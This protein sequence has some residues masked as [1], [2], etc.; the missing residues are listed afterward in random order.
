MQRYRLSRL[1]PTSSDLCQPQPLPMA[2]SQHDRLFILFLC[3]LISRII[4]FLQ[5]V[6]SFVMRVTLGGVEPRRS[7][8]SS[9]LASFIT[10]NSISV[11]SI[12]SLS[13]NSFR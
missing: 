12:Y 8:Y 11:I 7:I 4:D 5:F 6:T 13:T 1:P 2:L 9:S 3:P 10:A